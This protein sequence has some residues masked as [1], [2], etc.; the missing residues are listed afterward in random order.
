MLNFINY[1][2]TCVHI[3]KKVAYDE[4]Y[5]GELWIDLDGKWRPSVSHV[6]QFDSNDFRQI[7]DKLDE[8]NVNTK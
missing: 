2:S 6:T 8:L 1:S 4:E 7:A 5:V 3:R